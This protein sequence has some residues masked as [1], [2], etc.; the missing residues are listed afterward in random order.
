MLKNQHLLAALVALGAVNVI[1]FCSLISG[2]RESARGLKSLGHELNAA[3]EE[4]RQ[5]AE[6]LLQQTGELRR[7]L[8]ES[9]SAVEQLRGEVQEVRGQLARTRKA[10][11]AVEERLEKPAPQPGAGR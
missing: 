11:E 3:R 4:H 1:A 9:Q 10:L 8:D 2:E 7:R 6:G 5:A